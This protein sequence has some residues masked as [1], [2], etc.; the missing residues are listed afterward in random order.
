MLKNE[1]SWK[2][3]LSHKL[4]DKKEKGP[5]FYSKR[6]KNVQYWQLFSRSGKQLV[7][8][9]RNRQ[10]SLESDVLEGKRLQG[11]YAYL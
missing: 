2:L 9:K 3:H 6:N 1:K 5:N 7:Q 4:V 10:S 8:I 11:L